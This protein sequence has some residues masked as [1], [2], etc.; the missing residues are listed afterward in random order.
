M[1]LQT[2]KVW[3]LAKKFSTVKV[4]IK[5][6]ESFAQKFYCKH[7]LRKE[8]NFFSYVLEFISNYFNKNQICGSVEN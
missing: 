7:E 6:T 4:S 2:L 1:K 8:S 3:T 5:C